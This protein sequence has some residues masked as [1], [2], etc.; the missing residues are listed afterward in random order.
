MPEQAHCKGLQ[1]VST[2]A[3]TTRKQCK[4]DTS[5]SRSAIHGWLGLPAPITSPVSRETETTRKQ[6]KKEKFSLAS[7]L[8]ICGLLGFDIDLF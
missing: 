2:G 8:A 1:L 3:E 7:R 4:K 5:V 6:C